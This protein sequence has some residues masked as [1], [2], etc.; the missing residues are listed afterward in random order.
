MRASDRHEMFPATLERGAGQELYLWERQ[1]QCLPWTIRRTGSQM[2]VRGWD[3]PR[4][5]DMGLSHIGGASRKGTP[6]SLWGHVIS[7]SLF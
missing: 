2:G 6:V 1:E 5:W 4:K 3:R 7:A